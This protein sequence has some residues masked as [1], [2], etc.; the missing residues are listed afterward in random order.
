M[1]L[2]MAFGEG[3]E[4]GKEGQLDMGTL[5]K[6]SMADPDVRRNGKE[7]PKFTQKLVQDVKKMGT[8]DLERFSANVDEVKYLKGAQDFLKKEFSV[9]IEIYSTDNPEKPDPQNK[10]RFAVPWRPAIYIE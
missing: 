6:S 8:S 1:A 5:M 3:S 9:D 10:S 4:D 2:D 7:A